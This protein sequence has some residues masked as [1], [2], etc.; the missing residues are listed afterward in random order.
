MCVCVLCVNVCNCGHVFTCMFLHMQ[1]FAKDA[2]L[3]VFS[4]GCAL[5]GLLGL[6][7]N[8]WGQPLMCVRVCG[9]AVVC[10]FR[11]MLWG[12]RVSGGVCDVSFICTVWLYVVKCKGV[13]VMLV[14]AHTY[15]YVFQ[16]VFMFIFICV[17][18]HCCSCVCICMCIILSLSLYLSVWY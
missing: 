7:V 13:C 8:L 5:Q 15:L 9:F 17:P 14:Y 6:C 18:V 11:C 2:W 12:Y 4:P 16:C 1:V 3:C 10:V